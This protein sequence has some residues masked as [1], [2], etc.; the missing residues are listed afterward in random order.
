MNF[1]SKGGSFILLNSDDI[2][3]EI[4]VTCLPF[5]WSF[6]G[7]GCLAIRSNAGSFTLQKSAEADAHV[8]D[9]CLPFE[10]SFAA[11]GAREG[12]M[13]EFQNILVHII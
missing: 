7:V 11:E 6:N 12:K 2:G 1:K 9:G 10:C 8:L 13:N 4:V 5:E 3:P